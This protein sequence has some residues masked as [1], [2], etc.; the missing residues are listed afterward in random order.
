VGFS[1]SYVLLTLWSYTSHPWSQIDQHIPVV[2]VRIHIIRT[3]GI[4]FSVV[5]L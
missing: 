1:D 3:H 4:G 5:G 2:G